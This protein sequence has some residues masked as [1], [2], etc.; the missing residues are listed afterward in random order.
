MRLSPVLLSLA[1][2][3]PM[4]LDAQLIASTDNRSAALGRASPTA[5]IAARVVKAPTLDGKDD[6][7]MWLSAQVIDAFL[8]YEPNEGAEP[9]FKTEV[10]IAYDDKYLYVLGRM[11]D[12]A[13]DSIMALLSRR[14]VRTQSE[15]LKLVIDSYND[16]RT[17]YQFI[18]NPVGVKR[19]FFV[20]NDNTED[21]SWDGVWDVA[22]AIDSK[23]WVAEF[24]I[25]FSQ[26]RFNNKREHTFGLLIV[27]DIGRTGQ[28][29]SWPLFRRQTQ[30]YVSQAG[31]I[32]GLISVPTPRR[33]EMLPY[34]VTKNVT[35]P[36][37][38]GF[39]HEQQVTGGADIKYGLTSNLTIDATINPDFGQV[40]ADPAVL[41]LSSFETFFGE[42]RPFFLEGTGIF[43]YRTSCDDIDTGCT[44]LFY[45][46]RVGRYP[47]LRDDFGDARS[48]TATTILGA[49]KITGR[50]ARGT[51]IGVFNAVTQRETGPDDFTL[52]PLTNYAVARLRQEMADG[53]GDVGLMLTAVNRNLDDD[54]SP[55]LRDKAYTGGVDFRRRFW[56]KNYELFASLSGSYI[57]GSQ[58][59]IEATQRDARHRFQRPDDGVEFDP[60]RTHLW[61]DAQRITFSKFGGGITKFQTVYQ[62]FS[63]GFETNDL[64]F[65]AR[66]DEQ[67]FRNWF[68]FN[69]TKPKYFYR[70]G[71]Y[72][73]NHWAYWNTEGMPTSFGFNI[74]WHV[75]MK[76]FWWGHIGANA[77][78]VL[79]SQ[80]SDREARG[81]P[82]IRLS[83]GFNY[84]GGIESDSRKRVYASLFSGRY[85]N[86]D[87]R[88][89][90]YWIEPYVTYRSSS[91]FSASLG[92]YYEKEANDNQW[93]EN[94]TDAR[95]EH[96]T[97]AR[98]DQETFS[99]TSRINFT[100]TPTLSFE[101]Y[102]QPFVST[103]TYSNWREL[104]RPR[105]KD[106]DDRYKAFAKLDDPATPTHDESLDPPG[107]FNFKQFRSNSVVRWEYRPGSTIFLVWAQGRDESLDGASNFAL[108]RDYRDLFSAHPDNTFLI[109]ASFWF[110]PQ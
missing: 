21:P 56:N 46:R 81:G 65:L 36:E 109:K 49:A 88:S 2:A 67:L 37:G 47:S 17:A 60:T 92:G 83:P 31:E 23:G 82:A 97:F 75:Q 101:F 108:S 100:M 38:N 69:F 79:V 45:S 16:N 41:N 107:G 66:A 90:G 73:F 15:W 33:L 104:D 43:S 9:R 51:S 85:T 59:A 53:Q 63:P 40:E 106:Y 55:Y 42:R 64:G 39:T 8:E 4:V 52:E 105:A 20:Y 24:R 94:I 34:I 99:L 86:D 70:Q 76:N 35:L 103:G 74:N 50:L 30:G 98:L 32:S 72:N 84:W 3:L 44:G 48:A 93:L 87:G 68:Q 71:F 95:G 62:R 110:N 26:L 11:F 22:T 6:D 7:E 61:G 25:P 78:N 89:P 12:P 96:F 5:A 14:D 58:A 29:I 27:R 13:P 91:R 54:T 18:V 80:Y 102:G 1:L 28:R 57:H 10:R 19:D 77:N